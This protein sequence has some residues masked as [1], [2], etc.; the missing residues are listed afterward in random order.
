MT[1]PADSPGP[2][3]SRQI[4]LFED[5]RIGGSQASARGSEPQ[6][7]PELQNVSVVPDSDL[8]PLSLPKR[9]QPVKRAKS[10]APAS[11]PNPQKAQIDPKKPVP[12]PAATSAAQ[13][14]AMTFT[15]AAAAASTESTM[16]SLQPAAV[17]EAAAANAP[18]AVSAAKPDAG[19]AKTHNL[20]LEVGTF[21]DEFLANTVADKLNQLGFHTV[22]IHKNVLWMQSYRVQVGPY[23]SQKEIAE[24]QQGLAS[25]DFKTRL[26]N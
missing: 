26:V 20:Y 19:M 2:M 17:P 16:S 4:S 7:A 8:D 18:S 24:A 1:V 22:M 13:A 14:E 15:V 12:V 23:P 5:V 25:H 6:N 11:T 9:S 3:E 10:P 21:K